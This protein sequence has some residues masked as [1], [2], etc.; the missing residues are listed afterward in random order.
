MKLT[1]INIKGFKSFARETELF[2]N[3]RV[4]GIIGP[5]G[6]GKSNI[7]DA[8]RWVLGEQKPT[9][10]RLDNMPDVIFNGTKTV[11]KSSM[12]QVTLTFDNTKNVLATDY[13]SVAISRTL[14]SSGESE[15]RLNDIPCRLKDI[16][17]LF[18]DTGV[19]SDSYAI[20]AL[21]MVEDIL[22][23]TNDSRRF[24]FEQAA[25][26]SKFK[27][28]KKETLQQLNITKTDLDR[29]EDLIFEIEGNLKELDKQARKAKQFIGLK[30]QYK[31]LSVRLSLIKYDKFEE[32]FRE[33]SSNIDRELISFR[34]TDTIILSKEARLQ[35]LKK[36]SVI[37]DKDLSDFQRK[38]NSHLDKLRNNES[39]K[40]VLAQKLNFNKGK[41][42]ELDLEN[43]M[44]SARLE[45]ISNSLSKI[46]ERINNELQISSAL[47]KI[48]AEEESSLLKLRTHY[49][50]EKSRID[51]TNRKKRHLEELKYQLIRETAV[52][53]N[54]IDNIRKDVEIKNES[55]TKNTAEFDTL[56]KNLEAD[57]NKFL[58]LDHRL[59]DMN[60]IKE[61]N[62][63]NRE[64]I[65]HLIDDLSK[66]YSLLSRQL[67]ARKNE[68]KLI[69]NMIDKLEGFPESIKYLN[70]NW[71]SDIPLLSDIISTDERYKVALESFLEPFLNYFIV[72]NSLQ[73]L[74]AIN[75]L[76][77]SQKGKANFFVLDKMSPQKTKASGLT[78]FIPAK[79]IVSFDRKYENLIELLLGNVYLSPADLD[80]INVHDADA[81]IIDKTGSLVTGNY[82]I[83]GGS[84]GLFEG[85]KIGRKKGLEDLSST[86]RQLENDVKDVE[87][88]IENKRNELLSVDKINSDEDFKKL[89]DEY[90]NV[91]NQVS[92]GE[93]KLDL[94]NSNI[95]NLKTEIENS[96]GK[97]KE[98]KIRIDEFEVRRNNIEAELDSLTGQVTPEISEIDG[99]ME[100]LSEAS[101]RTNNARIESLKQQNLVSVLSKE[102]DFRKSDKTNLDT[103]IAENHLLL[104]KM[105]QESTEMEILLEKIDNE[106]VAQYKLKSEYES[107]LD[108]IEKEY[109][110]ERN[111]MATIE[112]EMS[113][114]KQLLNKS[115]YLINQFKEK[116]LDLDYNKRSI[117]ERLRIEF[118]L[119][120]EDVLKQPRIEE[121]EISLS[122]KVEKLRSRIDNFG[123]VNTLAIE[124]HDEMLLRFDN[125]Q[126]QK[127]D[128]LEAEKSLKKTIHEIE[129]TATELFMDAFQVIRSHFKNVFTTLFTQGDTCDLFLENPESPLDS[130]ILITAKPKG[131]R[132]RTISQ[133]SGGE[134]TLTAIA[135]LFSL[136]LFKPAPFCIFDEVDAPLDDANIMKFNNIIR[137][138]SS[139]SQFIVVTHNKS[140]MTAVDVLYGVFMQEP[141]VSEVT[142]VDFREF[143]EYEMPVSV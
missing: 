117:S 129:K 135:L 25:G 55:L 18:M 109:F 6:S 23:D 63:K 21:N 71:N 66:K 52:L 96:A 133:L 94:I 62:L 44:I 92:Q 121:D 125:I 53:N 107:Q 119:N 115:Q 38:I 84:I 138:F 51:E 40:Q 75:I 79:E 101:S 103:K 39:E 137:E 105:S 20:I 76:R 85:K 65:L 58:L 2:F 113:E 116:H 120:I 112:N 100:G 123:E 118:G 47:D 35:E 59:K 1:G 128:I 143:A 11:K 60:E 5:N 141:G 64:N 139:N 46:E 142:E 87:T 78:G 130:K 13:S 69:K 10:L 131:K 140:T 127:T 72:E 54:N 41:T 83:S 77:K 102:Q 33:I 48:L 134:K 34:E 89:A 97:L 30:N 3:E 24:M 31:D 49:E 114:K 9:E 4:T 15:Y 124:A 132:P 14:F 68:F 42:D 8:I 98:N 50:K 56:K 43:S 93:Y 57:R 136:Y 36:N 7:V 17:N 67:D 32:S 110:E 73:A 122:D 106:L 81:V 37:R 80:E 22:S 12:A 61:A 70:K 99:L 108:D 29:V 16:R 28:R 95:F 74:E 104:A 45:E 126:R 26:I 27:K 111:L 88:E 86:I 19:S 90:N 82:H 91:K